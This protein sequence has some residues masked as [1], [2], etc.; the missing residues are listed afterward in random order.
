MAFLRENSWLWNKLYGWALRHA[1]TPEGYMIPES[2]T[3]RI[4]CIR[5][6]LT[7]RGVPEAGIHT[8][9]AIGDPRYVCGR[10]KERA[11]AEKKAALIV[12]A[13]FPR[14]R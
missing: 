7:E 5:A 14:L 4:E 8:V 9:L 6:R 3:R 1:P 12:R 11:C 2:E 13:Y 10:C